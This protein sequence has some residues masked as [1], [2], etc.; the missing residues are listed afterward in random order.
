MINSIRKSTTASEANM[1]ELLFQALLSEVDQL[2]NV[3][4]S[5]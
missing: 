1:N 3:K 5:P 2:Q 4:D